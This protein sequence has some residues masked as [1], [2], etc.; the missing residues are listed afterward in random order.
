MYSLIITIGSI[1]LAAAML[2]S[3]LFH[4]GDI[5]SDAR[6]QAV[7]A[8]LVNEGSQVQAAHQMN[9]ALGSGTLATLPELV[10]KGYLRTSPPFYDVNWGWGV[11]APGARVGFSGAVLLTRALPSVTSSEGGL[12]VCNALEHMSG[13]PEK[14]NLLDFQTPIEGEL[15]GR[16]GCMQDDVLTI[17]YKL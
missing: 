3:T 17:Y 5:Y 7:A 12:R 10:A 2:A 4:G 15:P 1:A 11:F 16:F 14:A 6:A 13:R 8:A 9:L